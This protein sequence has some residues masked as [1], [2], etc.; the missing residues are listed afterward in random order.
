VA[1]R[2]NEVVALTAADFTAAIAERAYLKAERRGFAPG[3]EV[4]DW[5]AAEEELRALVGASPS[6]KAKKP[7]ARRKG[8]A[9]AK[10]KNGAAGK[11]K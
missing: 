4:E 2:P 10:T 5:L 9:S 1:Q 8:A 7:A 11:A 3:H 6:A